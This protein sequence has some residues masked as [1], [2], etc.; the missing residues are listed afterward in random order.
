MTTTSGKHTWENRW[1]VGCVS[2][3]FTLSVISVIISHGHFDWIQLALSAFCFF[4]TF[5]QRRRHLGHF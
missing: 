5:Y 3:W 2:V 4:G 1:F